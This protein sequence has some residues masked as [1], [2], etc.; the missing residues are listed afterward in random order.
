MAGATARECVGAGRQPNIRPVRRTPEGLEAKAAVSD[1][2]V[3]L[4]TGNAQ[5][6]LTFFPWV[7]ETSDEFVDGLAALVEA[8][9]A[10]PNSQL[11]VRT[12]GK[13]EQSSEA[14]R[15]LIP[16]NGSWVLKTRTDTP[17]AE[18]LAQADLL[19]SDMSSTIM[20][21]IHARRPVLLWGGT[22]R[23]IHLP[24]RRKPPTPDD[25]TAVY[26]VET[27]GE[28]APMIN[29]ILGAHAGRP[30]TDD[31]VADFVWHSDVPDMKDLA[32]AIAAGDFRHAWGE[33]NLA[34]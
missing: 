33:G 16:E 22:Q 20:Q 24:A 14:L 5:R 7:F 30:L 25:R 12:K 10:V 6:W 17:F 31:E 3:V 27:S 13:P 28:L 21:A 34:S 15:S 8:M 2:H 1:H 9:S 18:D 26:T 29:A 19:V 32:R 23:Y 4:H 11:V